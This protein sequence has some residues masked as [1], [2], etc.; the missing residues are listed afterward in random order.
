MQ[1]PSPVALLPAGLLLLIAPRFPAPLHPA[2][3]LPHYPAPMLPRIRL[4]QVRS[5]L[6]YF[7]LQ[8][9][10]RPKPPSLLRYPRSQDPLPNGRSAPCFPSGHPCSQCSRHR[11][12]VPHSAGSS[13]ARHLHSPARPEGCHSGRWCS[14]RCRK[15]TEVLWYSKGGCRSAPPCVLRGSCARLRSV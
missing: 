4:P 3:P 14:S 2:H 7:H 8:I 9:P 10:A 5:L 12:S 6:W 1:A 15:N 11:G 13:A